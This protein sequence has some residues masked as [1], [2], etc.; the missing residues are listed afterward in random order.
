[1]VSWVRSPRARTFV[2]VRAVNHV[3]WS[4]VVSAPVR[5]GA[6]GNLRTRTRKTAPSFWRKTEPSDIAVAWSS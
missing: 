4:V 2:T 3:R 1:M 6:L 5:E